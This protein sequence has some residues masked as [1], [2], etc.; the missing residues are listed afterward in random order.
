[1]V[2]SKDSSVSTVAGYGLEDWHSTS[3]GDPQ[4]PDRLRV[5]PALYS[6]CTST[7]LTEME[8]LESEAD[9]SSPSTV[10]VKEV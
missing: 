3:G 1:L 6:G 4:L 8:S 2:S 10:E 5:K 9:H 7:R